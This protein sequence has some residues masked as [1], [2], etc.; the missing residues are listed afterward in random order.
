V[1]LL[2]AAGI[3]FCGLLSFLNNANAELVRV[4]IKADQADVS[5]SGQAL[6]FHGYQE[7]VR[8]V[9]IPRDQQIKVRTLIKDQ[10]KVWAV[11][12]NNQERE[13]IVAEN[14]L[15]LRGEGLRID[16]QSLPNQVILSHST[17]S[18]ID[19]V[20]VVPLD[21]YI[22]GVISSEMPLSWPIESLKAQAVAS[23]SYALSVMRERR[24]KPYHLESSVLDQVFR[25]VMTEDESD[26]KIQKAKLA[27][28]ETAGIELFTKG[29]HLLKA[30]YH[31]DCGGKTTTA[32]SVWSAGV[33]TGVAQ[34]ASC[35]T[36]PKAAWTLQ[37]SKEE[38]NQRVKK[39]LHTNVPNAVS[40]IEILRQ[41]VGER[42]SKVTLAFNDGAEK[43]LDSNEFRKMVGFQ[44]LRSTLFDLETKDSTYVF[45]G[46]GFGHGVGLC[47]WGSR[48]LGLQGKNFKQI[49]QHYYPLAEVRLASSVAQNGTN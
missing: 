5:I 12:V 25:H 22:V 18:K 32:K 48:A 38:L 45:K 27:V 11:Q 10:K 43:S 42:V 36:S 29:G 35:P 37:L 23:R 28:R 31:A 2:F 16:G 3:F 9:A 47:Q 20:G 34:D 39:Y 19:V 4:R 26:E 30:F 15:L 49:L 33:N 8:P 41:G 6:R 13:I 14:Y 44:D 21:D 24:N 17:Q 46:K 40:R 7:I 1:K